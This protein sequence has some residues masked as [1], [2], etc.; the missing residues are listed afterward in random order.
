MQESTASLQVLK[1]EHLPDEGNS[2]EINSVAQENDRGDYI[3]R[4]HNF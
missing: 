2:D 1:N 3:R 4:N